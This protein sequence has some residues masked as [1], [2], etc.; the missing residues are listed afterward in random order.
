MGIDALHDIGLSHGD[1]KPSNILY[2]VVGTSQINAIIADL[3]SC[4]MLDGG[5]D[6]SAETCTYQFRPGSVISFHVLLVHI[7]NDLILG[8]AAEGFNDDFEGKAEYDM[9]ALDC[10]SVGAIIYYL[11]Y[12]SYLFSSSLDKGDPSR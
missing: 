7:L 6:V 3:G 2:S 10:Y 9:R 8:Y 11:I 12:K 5:S 1:L 4:A